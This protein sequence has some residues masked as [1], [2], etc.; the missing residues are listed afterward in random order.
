[1][2]MR[3][4]RRKAAI[5]ISK[6]EIELIDEE[7]N[8]ENESLLNGKEA[9]YYPQDFTTEKEYER[10]WVRIRS[11][12]MCSLKSNKKIWRRMIA[13]RHLFVLCQLDKHDHEGV[14]EERGNSE[15]R[16]GAHLHDLN[17]WYALVCSIST[18]R[19]CWK[20]QRAMRFMLGFVLHRKE[21]NDLTLWE[22]KV[23]M[24]WSFIV[25]V[26]VCTFV[27]HDLEKIMLTKFTHVKAWILCFCLDQSVKL[28]LCFKNWHTDWQPIFNK[29]C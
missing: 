13:E 26:Q 27:L 19:V 18:W 10:K 23:K 2:R 16:R 22:R 12:T 7:E 21:P 8:E 17:R 6:E 11:C 28:K 1:M 20:L 24:R 14:Q 15:P 3:T 4:V 25:P 9:L 29:F 5:T